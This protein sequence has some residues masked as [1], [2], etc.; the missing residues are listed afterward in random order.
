MHGLE[1]MVKDGSWISWFFENT[2]LFIDYVVT[3]RVLIVESY[4]KCEGLDCCFVGFTKPF[5]MVLREHFWKSMKKL[6]VPSQY[7]LAISEIDEKVIC[8]VFMRDGISNFLL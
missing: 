1:R 6:K 4:L 8:N 2:T 5:N 3:F 7:M